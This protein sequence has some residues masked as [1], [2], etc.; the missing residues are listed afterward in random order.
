MAVAHLR[1]GPRGGSENGR[2]VNVR[3]PLT[4]P[5]SWRR[6][7]REENDPSTTATAGTK[8]EYTLTL[9][10]GSYILVVR[11]REFPVKVGADPVRLNI[12]L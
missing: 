8:G 12:Q 6:N 9:Q 2:S 5:V 11:G 4:P 3:R 1:C 7:D 10:P